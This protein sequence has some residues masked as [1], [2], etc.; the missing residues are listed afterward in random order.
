MAISSI[1]ASPTMQSR[2][3]DSISEEVVGSIPSGSTMQSRKPRRFPGNRNP[4]NSGGLV[5]RIVVCEPNSDRSPA[6][7]A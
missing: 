4:R 7:C 6:F 5:R 2:Q 3:T 1:P